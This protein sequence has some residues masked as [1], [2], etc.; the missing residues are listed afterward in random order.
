MIVKSD[1]K[2]RRTQERTWLSVGRSEIPWH[3][4]SVWGKGT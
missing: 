2:Q 3:Y 4:F 1:G